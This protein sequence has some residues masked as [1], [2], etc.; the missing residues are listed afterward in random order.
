MGRELVAEGGLDLRNPDAHRV[1]GRLCVE[2]SGRY[3]CVDT[4]SGGHALD[5]AVERADGRARQGA[6]ATHGVS[7]TEQ[8]ASDHDL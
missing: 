7:V 3:R 2:R 8:R 1:L 6:A 4:V 5:L